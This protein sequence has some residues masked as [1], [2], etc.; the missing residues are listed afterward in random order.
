MLEWI[1][2]KVLNTLLSV[3]V[4]YSL[5]VRRLTLESPLDRLLYSKDTRLVVHSPHPETSGKE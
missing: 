2:F 1:D 5:G 4:G 3:L